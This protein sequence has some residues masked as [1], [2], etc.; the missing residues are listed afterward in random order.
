MSLLYNCLFIVFAIN[1]TIAIKTTMK[2]I[3]FILMSVLFSSFKRVCCSFRV[4][5]ELF[6]NILEVFLRNLN[7]MQMHDLHLNLLKYHEAI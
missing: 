6:Q 7:L 5:F 3:G 2:M 4:F 1:Q